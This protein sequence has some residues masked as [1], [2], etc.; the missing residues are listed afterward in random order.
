MSGPRVSV[1]IPAYNRADLLPRAVDS[2]LAQTVDDIEVIVVDDG[3]TDDTL[4]VLERYDDDRLCVLEH[5]TN[6]GVSAARNTGIESA[7]GEYVAFLDSDDYWR[8]GKL[9][10]QLSALDGRS[11]GWIAAYCDSDRDGTT[12]LG[13]V[14]D[15]LEDRVRALSTPTGPVEGGT[16]L[17]AEILLMRLEFGP[18]S[19]LLV[20][21]SA[22]EAVGG[23][24]E[25]LAIYED[26]DLAI[27]L[28]SVGKL[29][30]VDDTLAV[31]SDTGDYDADSYRDAKR[32][33]L[34]KHDELV[35]TLRSEGIDVVDLQRF[36]LA[37]AY[38]REGRFVRAGSHLSTADATP[39]RLLRLC[40]WS[41]LGIAG[42]FGGGD[43]KAGSA[44]ALPESTASEDGGPTGARADAGEGPT[45]PTVSVVV[46]YSAEYTPPEMLDEAKR[47]VAAQTVDTELIVVDDVDT[48]PAD[49]RNA[50]L[51]RADTRYVAFLD[52]DD[53]WAPDKLARQLDRMGET[54]AG[55]CV[56]GPRATTLD[57]FV[58][59]VFVGDLSEVTSAV[60][61]DTEQVGVRFETGLDRGEDLLYVMEA[62]TEGGV[63]CLP[64]LFERRHHEGSMMASG[65][66]VDEYRE[67]AK[68]F[69]YLVSQRVPEAQPYLP[70]YYNQLYTDLGVACHES[71]EHDRAV[72]YL[73]RAVRISP[74]PFS[75]LYLCRSLWYRAV[76]FSP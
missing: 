18:G 64:D 6:R 55:L 68:R 27:R 7:A 22:L 58:Y 30:H 44:D 19:T 24:D 9:A 35:A 29:A 74:H 28:L 46:P 17:A 41:L 36:A 50:G 67:H 33:W 49:A 57:D 70:V 52:A 31:T 14:R 66:A 61:V 2:A 32:R 12:R 10:A 15:T 48:G 42:L 60:L 56:Q 8:P 38:L 4:A 26:W 43:R 37:G 13:W 53:L 62:A 16:D 65:M 71:G 75:L 76:S 3:S 45:G 23:F 59:E 34:A 73:G 39:G 47:T 20:E 11:G 54:G 40:W 21:R 1:V 51:E 25:S 5:G 72:T 69:G 63:C